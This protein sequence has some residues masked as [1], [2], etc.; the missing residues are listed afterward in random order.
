MTQF[1]WQQT[2]NLGSLYA[3]ETSEFVVK[4]T[5]STYNISYQ[6][7]S[8][9]LPPN[10]SINRDGTISGTAAFSTSTTSTVY[11]FSVAAVD[12]Y[13]TTS[14]TTNISIT[15]NQNTS[16]EFTKIYCR[17]FLHPSKRAEFNSLISNSN[18]FLPESLY[19][20]LDPNFG[21]QKDL[22]MYIHFGI[23]KLSITEYYEI[24]SRN[25]YKRR[26][27]LGPLKFARTADSIGQARYEVIYAEVID[28]YSDYISKKSIPNQVIINGITYYPAGIDNMR[29]RIQSQTTTTDLLDPKYMRFRQPTSVFVSK[30]FK[31]V[32]LCY[33]LPGQGTKIIKKIKAN[34]FK[35]NEID[36]EIDRMIVESSTENNDSKY[37]RTNKYSKIT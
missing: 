8:G 12:V 3:G 22:K 14:T 16:T 19:R 34:G 18:I 6:L 35:F 4:L 28:K 2:G 32:P 11:N 26:F 23:K 17:P 24:L 29:Q 20:P 33:V 5:S 31:V 30:Y 21:I 15:V 37:L 25:F 9:T 27:V 1:V 10:L 7:G 13:G 36:F